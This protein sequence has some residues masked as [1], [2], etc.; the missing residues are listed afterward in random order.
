[1]G[2]V[3]AV[4]SIMIKNAQSRNRFLGDLQRT[5]TLLD[6]DQTASA[7]SS[8]RFAGVISSSTTKKKKGDKDKPIAELVDIWNHVR[9]FALSNLWSL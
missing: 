5:A 9:P 2:E 3:L 7:M 8:S 6:C 4:S 1:M